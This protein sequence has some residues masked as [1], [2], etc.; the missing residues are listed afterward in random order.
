V[1]AIDDNAAAKE[2]RMIRR[3]IVLPLP[4]RILNVG[5]IYQPYDAE[6]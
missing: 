2:V 3:F 1:N 6:E 5:A 4:N